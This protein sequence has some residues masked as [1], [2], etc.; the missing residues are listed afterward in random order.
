MKKII[1]LLFFIANTYAF[2]IGEQV[3]VSGNAVNPV[4]GDI[5]DSVVFYSD[6]ATYIQKS[7]ENDQIVKVL[8]NHN[9]F[10]VN[11]SNIVR[12]KESFNS[13]FP[14][15][16]FGFGYS[17]FFMNDLALNGFNIILGSDNKSINVGGTFSMGF[18]KINIDIPDTIYKYNEKDTTVVMKYTIINPGFY[19]GQNKFK[20]IFS[21]PIL[22]SDYLDTKVGFGIGGQ[23]NLKLND[24]DVAS[25]FMYC[26]FIRLY[27]VNVINMSIGFSF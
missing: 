24:S 26:G 7:S 5:I 11:K 13:L 9:Y 3:I 12:L 14:N 22:K 16:Y 8:Y 19:I 17:G 25:P 1:M 20:A 4:N 27:N 2:Y 18:D 10:Y 21:V 6:T 23:I 15:T